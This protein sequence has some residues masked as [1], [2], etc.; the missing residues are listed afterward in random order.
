VK[1]KFLARTVE[2]VTG[3]VKITVL[4]FGLIPCMGIFERY[5]SKMLQQKR[6]LEK[7]WREMPTE[8]RNQNDEKR[9]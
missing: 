7:L 8:Q 2:K 9:I 6:N 3:V 4:S 1:G 5:L